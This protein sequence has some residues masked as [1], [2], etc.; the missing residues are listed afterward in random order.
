[1]TP[2][3]ILKQITSVAANPMMVI[4]AISTFVASY[5]DDHGLDRELICRM[6]RSH[7]KKPIDVQSER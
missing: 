3:D 4:A 7:P 5:C 6:I 2:Q 1:M